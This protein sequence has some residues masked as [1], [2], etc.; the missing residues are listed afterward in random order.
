[1]SVVVGLDHTHT[2]PPTHTVSKKSPVQD[3]SARFQKE[4]KISPTR[5]HVN[6]LQNA[7]VSRSFHRWIDDLLK[8]VDLY[9]CRVKQCSRGRQR[10]ESLSLAMNWVVTS[11]LGVGH[12]IDSTHSINFP[13]GADRFFAQFEDCVYMNG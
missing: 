12:S 11:T 9:S 3:V 8:G 6:E 10:V 4:E 13:S 5:C 1:M 7:Y 2:A